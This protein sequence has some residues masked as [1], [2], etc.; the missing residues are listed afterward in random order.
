M[1]TVKDLF[2]I[3]GEAQEQNREH[4]H[5]FFNYSGHV[6][7]IEIRF[8]PCGWL[9]REENPIEEKFGC[10][11]DNEDGIQAAYWFIKSKLR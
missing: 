8:Y 7:R 4:N 11:I 10:Y 3:M 1:K 9:N 5:W 6:N 2:A